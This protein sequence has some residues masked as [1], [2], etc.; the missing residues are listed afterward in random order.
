[1]VEDCWVAN[2]KKLLVPNQLL[3]VHLFIK[4][5]LSTILWRSITCFLETSSLYQPVKLI[6]FAFLS[7]ICF[8][9][10]SYCFWDFLECWGMPTKCV[11][12]PFV[13]NAP[14]LYPLRASTVRN[15]VHWERMGSLN[16]ALLLRCYRLMYLA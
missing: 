1:M 7:I 12:N 3:L 14:F 6:F 9:Y 4:R 13:P 8:F 16:M 10:I 15:W 2:N 5:K 11:F